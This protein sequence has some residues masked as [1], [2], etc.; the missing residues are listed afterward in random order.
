MH[1][2]IYLIYVFIWNASLYTRTHTYIHILRQILSLKDQELVEWRPQASPFFCCC[3]VTNYS[4][5]AQA[6]PTLCHRLTA[7]RQASVSTTN[8]RSLL[9]LMSIQSVM[10]SNH[11]ILLSPSPPAFNLSQHQGL[12]YWSIRASVLPMTIQG[13]FPLGFTD[14]ISLLSEGLSRDFPSATDQKHQFF[15]I[16]HFSIPLIPNL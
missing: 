4:Q 15:G 12:L 5:V 6:C 16:H 2:Y 8:S 10:P 9:K 11:L 1:V 3:S 7:A 14:L 13:W